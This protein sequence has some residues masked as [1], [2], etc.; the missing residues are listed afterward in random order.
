MSVRR[1]RCRS[2]AN[3]LVSHTGIPGFRY[4][5]PSLLESPYPYRVEVST[6]R[7][8][9]R[10][11]ETMKESLD[12]SGIPVLIRYDGHIPGPYAAWA[13]TPLERFCSLMEAYH[14]KH[15]RRGT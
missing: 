3:Y 12:H 14:D 10:L 4:V 1:D 15:I 9:W 2:V 13:I 7:S 6:A 11:G 5:G 8:Y